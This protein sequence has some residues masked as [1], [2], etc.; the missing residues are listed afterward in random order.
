MACFSPSRPYTFDGFVN[1][2]WLPLCVRDGSHRPSTIAMYTNILKVILPQFEGI[3]LSDISGVHISQYLRWLRNDY[4]KPDGKPLAEKSIKHHYNILGLIF[5]YAE[6]QDIIDKN[7]MKKVDPPKVT[8]K[9]VDALTEDEAVRFFNALLACDFEFR[10]VLQVLLTTGLRR[11]ECLGL[12]WADIDF[13]NG[14]LTVNRSTTYTPE[15]GI[16][17]AAPKTAHSVRTIPV[18]GSTLS[19]LKQLQKQ[20]E[21]EHP[22]TL[23]S[24]AFVFSRPDAPFEP[25]DPSAITRRMKRFVRSA[26]LPDVSPHDLR[27]SCASLLLSSGADIKSVQEILGHADASTTLNFYVKTD[28]NQMRSA[29]EKYAKRMQCL[30]HKS[31]NGCVLHGGFPCFLP[32]TNRC[33][34]SAIPWASALLPISERSCSPAPEKHRLKSEKVRFTNRHPN[35]GKQVSRG[36]LIFIVFFCSHQFE[37]SGRKYN[38][39]YHLPGSRSDPR[40]P[41][42]FR[43]FPQTQAQWVH[44]SQYHDSQKD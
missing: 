26:G 32:L 8:K 14:T 40:F 7:P 13:Q 3:P 29:T 30:S 10:C 12:Q 1:E 44:N 34:R 23:L 39:P 5:A 4:R 11:G 21:Q 38:L 35:T 41:Y 19:L 27:H 28:L 31:R 18:V 43:F 37:Y 22:A 6:K 33:R 36:I 2:V 17:V 20:Q 42:W 9:D 24:G 15:C 25:R 16:T